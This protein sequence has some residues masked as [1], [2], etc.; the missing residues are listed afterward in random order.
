MLIIFPLRPIFRPGVARTQFFTAAA[1]DSNN[2]PG[3]FAQQTISIPPKEPPVAQIPPVPRPRTSLS[4]PT[5]PRKTSPPDSASGS[6]SYEDLSIV[7]N[8]LAD[9]VKYPSASSLTVI[10]SKEQNE[11]CGGESNSELNGK[12]GLKVCENF[13]KIKIW[14]KFETESTES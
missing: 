8:N 7:V 12:W 9:A 1:T 5:S 2:S 6:M 13:L 10:D 14:K 3:Y 4:A 11:A